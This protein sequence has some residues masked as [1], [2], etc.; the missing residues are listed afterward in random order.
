[1]FKWLGKLF[2]RGVEYPDFATERKTIMDAARERREKLDDHPDRLKTTRGARPGTRESK[3]RH[4]GETL[5]HYQR[6][7]RE[8]GADV[9]AARAKIRLEKQRKAVASHVFPEQ[10]R[11]RKRDDK[12]YEDGLTALT[13]GSLAGS[14][15]RESAVVDNPPDF[16]PGGGSFG[17][18]GASES[19][20]SPA[21][22]E[23]SSD[24]TAM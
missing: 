6:R 20:D 15:S 11:K 7:M 8:A 13:L 12:D 17:G 3:M 21:A 10:E 5:E 2:G 16:E 18:G 24:P 9:R 4:A 22:P 19:F 1:M 14:S 23:V